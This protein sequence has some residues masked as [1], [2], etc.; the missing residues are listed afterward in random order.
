MKPQYDAVRLVISGIRAPD[1]APTWREYPAAEGWTLHPGWGEDDVVAWA[2]RRTA[3][4]TPTRRTLVQVL[5][6]RLAATGHHN[7]RRIPLAPGER[8]IHLTYYRAMDH[9]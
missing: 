1:D 4:T 8:V 2:D 6:D 3:A 9:N 5:R 7:S